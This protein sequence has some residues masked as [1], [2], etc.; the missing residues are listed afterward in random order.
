MG[1]WARGSSAKVLI[2]LI[3]LCSEGG[4]KQLPRRFEPP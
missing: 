3:S 2:I 4:R 1:D